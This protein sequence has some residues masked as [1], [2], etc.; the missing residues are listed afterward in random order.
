MIVGGAEEGEEGRD[1]RGSG[2]MEE[3][4]RTL[5][6]SAEEVHFGGEVGRW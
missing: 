4:K 1:W 3:G 5:L 6:E 2:R